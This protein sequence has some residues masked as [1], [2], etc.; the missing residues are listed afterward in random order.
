MTLD[1][2]PEVNRDSR[3]RRERIAERAD[4]SP[5]IDEARIREEAGVL[6]APF[7]L[8]ASKFA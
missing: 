7:E 8:A 3:F 4:P 1:N 2:L 6:L 5:E